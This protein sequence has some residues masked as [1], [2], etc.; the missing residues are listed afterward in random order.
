M[1]DLPLPIADFFRM[2]NAHDGAGLSSLFSEDATVIDEGEGKT[3][4]GSDEIQ[5]WVTKSIAGLNLHTEVQSSAEQ[6]GQWVVDTVMTGDFK[7][8]PARFLYSIGLRDDK[9]SGLRVEF[10]GSLEDSS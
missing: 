10:L 9:I 5:S 1:M 6:D 4:Q 3:M 7:A 8:S 2:K